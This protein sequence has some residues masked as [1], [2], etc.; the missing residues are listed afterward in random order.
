MARTAEQ[1]VDKNGFGQKIKVLKK[2]SRDV[3]VGKGNKSFDS[4]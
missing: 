3:T 2:H 1:I 4:N